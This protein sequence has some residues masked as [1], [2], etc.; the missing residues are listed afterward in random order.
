MFAE[1]PEIA[2]R[3]VREFGE[4]G[5]QKFSPT[6]ASESHEVN[7]PGVPRLPRP[8][9]AKRD[10]SHLSPSQSARHSPSSR[11]RP[12]EKESMQE[13]P[14]T[15]VAGS[16]HTELGKPMRHTGF[17]GRDHASAEKAIIPRKAGPR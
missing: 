10:F 13:A 12:D 8:H 11:S 9:G 5:S 2:R 17:K 4:G 14:V 1:H 16:R 7:R 3:W 15:Y 6:R